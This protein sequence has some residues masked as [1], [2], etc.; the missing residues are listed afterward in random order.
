MTSTRLPSFGLAGSA[1]G[2]ALLFAPATALAGGCPVCTTAMDCETASPG[3]CT[4]TNPCFC[5]MHDH[6]VGC[7]TARMICCPGQGCA[8]FSGRPSCEGTTCSVVD[9]PYPAGD[10]GMSG[11]DAGSTGTDAGSS[12]TD[13]GSSSGTDAGPSAGTDAGS[14]SGTDAGTGGGMDAGP[15]GGMDDG[16][17]CRVTGGRT[18]NGGLALLALT[19]LGLVV[20]RRRR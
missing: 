2:L 17:G 19:A 11:A 5:V 1:I 12:G 3:L 8:T 16:C 4:D 10:A 20:R 18:S 7:G 13:A 15:S 6:D 9:G 14:S